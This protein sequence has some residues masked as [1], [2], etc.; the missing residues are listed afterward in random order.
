M[1]SKASNTLKKYLQLEPVSTTREI[2]QFLGENLLKLKRDGIILGL[3]GGL[4]SAVVANLCVRAVGKEKVLCLI[5]PE[6]DSAKEHLLDA[7]ELAQKLDIKTKQ[8]DITP[9]LEKLGIYKLFS[10]TGIPI[11]KKFKEIFVTKGYDF[12]THKTGKTAFAD[13]MLGTLNTAPFS[14]YLR[15]GN[16]YYRVKHRLRMLILYYYAEQENRLIVGAA[17][18]TEYS[19][20]FF[21]KYG[22]DHAADVMPLLHL[23]KTQVKKLA[24]HLD[25]PPKILDKPSSPDIL[26]GLTDE[27]ALGISYEILDLILV[28]LEKGWQVSEIASAIKIEEEKIK[29]IQD[30]TIDSAHMRKLIAMS[31]IQNGCIESEN[32]RD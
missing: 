25:I 21:V 29:T 19:I 31:S 1:V 20:G 18:K 27:Q 9:Y 8:I 32:Q 15:K 26:P 28:G 17:N 16:A 10:K 24:K 23:Y 13:S 4:D 2:E 5:M 7:L 12:Y 6:K 14:S 3:S 11:P 22:C 30:L